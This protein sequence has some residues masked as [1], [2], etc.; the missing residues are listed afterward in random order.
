ME[1][2]IIL[3]ERNSHEMTLLKRKNLNF[4]VGL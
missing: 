1:H 4:D 2:K 3:L